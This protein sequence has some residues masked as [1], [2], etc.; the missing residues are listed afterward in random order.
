MHALITVLKHV[1]EDPMKAE[2]IGIQ[3][4]GM[5]QWIAAQTAQNLGICANMRFLFPRQ[6]VEL[7]L[8]GFDVEDDQLQGQKERLNADVFF[9]SVMERINKSQYEENRSDHALSNIQEYIREDK[10]GKR[11]YQLSMKIAKLFDDYQIYRPHMLMEWQ[12]K[13]RHENLNDP[14]ERWQA[15]LWNT[16]ASGDP[17]NHIAYQIIHFLEKF[18]IKNI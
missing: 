14:D 9:W 4:R 11:Q 5:K 17:Q 7:I 13:N 12:E 6:M 2:W 18:D 16:I 1:P 10:T 15:W 3:S 8:T